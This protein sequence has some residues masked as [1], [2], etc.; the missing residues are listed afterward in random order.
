[1]KSSEEEA[2]IP[3]SVLAQCRGR[4]AIQQQ[5][6]CQACGV[7]STSHTEDNRSLRHPQ[8]VT[9]GMLRLHHP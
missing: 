3:S 1:M 5:L 7:I 8:K 2:T 9:S 4:N 6:A